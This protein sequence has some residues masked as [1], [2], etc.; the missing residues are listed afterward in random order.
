[1]A[2]Y[3]NTNCICK[4][5]LYIRAAGMCIFHCSR[6]D[7]SQHSVWGTSFQDKDFVFTAMTVVNC[8][9]IEKAI[10]LINKGSLIEC[11]MARDA[12]FKNIS[13]QK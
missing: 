2:L 11:E 6:V 9:R 4:H 10:L 12:Y 3:G 1:M 7:G 8:D 13:L 5:N